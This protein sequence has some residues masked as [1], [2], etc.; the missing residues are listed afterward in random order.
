MKIVQL[1]P[2]Y[3]P[4]NGGQEVFISN[5]SKQLVKLGHEICIVTSDFPKSKPDIFDGINIIRY[6]CIARPLRNPITPGLFKSYKKMVKYDVI[7]THNEHSFAAMVAAIFRT[8]NNKPLIIT[9]HGQLKF[10]NN[11]ANMLERLYNKYIGYR[12]LQLSDAVVAL[13]LSD[14]QYISSLGVSP[15]K[16]RVIPNG[17]DPVEL[18]QIYSSD[19][20]LNHQL[21]EFLNTKNKIILFVGP[22]IQRKGIEYLIKS[23][24]YI[25]KDK[26]Y[27]DVGFVF[28]GTGDFMNKSKRLCNHLK[29]NK[30]VYFTHYL[31][32]DELL[33]VY[34]SSDLF[35]LPSLSEGLP[36]SILEAMY[37]GLPVVAT[38]IPGVVDHFKN[39][40]LLIPP[41]NEIKLAEAITE[42]L[43][44]DELCK[45]LSKIG[46]EL[47]D[48]SYTWDAIARRYEK[49]Y[50]NMMEGVN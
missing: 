31:K 48:A 42:L 34:S 23:I 50:L 28:T 36:T 43:K 38:E 10:D 25:M 26:K 17:I 6:K 15:E 37:F 8:H 1:V 9:S 4:Y 18:N 19:L 27:N 47:I 46:K 44:D 49:I 45:K 13:S 3:L 16:I 5:L 12:I 30:F 7:H 22:I 21:N 40:A 2:Y 35:V 33:K 29:V 24:P 20:S 32:R 14:K 39:F 11:F 41:K